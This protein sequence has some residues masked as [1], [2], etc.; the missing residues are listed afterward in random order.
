MTQLL[1][2]QRFFGCQAL[3]YHFLGLRSKAWGANMDSGSPKG[4]VQGIYSRHVG[5]GG[6]SGPW[7][8]IVDFSRLGAWGLGFRV[9]R[10]WGFWFSGWG[11]GV[12]GGGF[13]V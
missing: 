5:T 2:V 9:F 13:R 11:F 12:G 1:E 6:P 10:V 3:S 4:Y 7:L 8:K